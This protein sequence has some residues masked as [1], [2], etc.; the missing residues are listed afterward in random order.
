MTNTLARIKQTG[1]NFEIVVDLDEALKFKNNKISEVEAEGDKIFTD[2]KKGQVAS[3]PDLEQAFGT[4]DTN[5]IVEK[6]IKN[7]EV[8]LTQ[9]HRDEGKEKTLGV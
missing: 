2:S 9:E 4:T 7:G 5:T 6:I 3:N 8:L 1:K